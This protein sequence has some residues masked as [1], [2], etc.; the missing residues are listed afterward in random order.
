M[1]NKK[2]II[3]IVILILIILGLGSFIYYDKFYKTE[4]EKAILTTIDGTNF[5]LSTLYKIGDILN[6]FDVAFG[7]S[8]STYLGYIYKD[9]LYAKDFDEKAALYGTIY[10]DLA[11][12]N[13]NKILFG[14]NVKNNFENIF[15][16]NLTYNSS[17]ILDGEYIN[18]KYIAASDRYNYTI[19]GVY[20][21]YSPKYM[22]KTISTSITKDSIIVKRKV[23]YVE[24]NTSGTETISAN[25]YTDSGKS[26]NIGTIK[27]K[28]GI[29]NLN[30]IM[31]KYSSRLNT[32][33]Y[34]F[35]QSSDGD[36][37]FYS[38]EKDK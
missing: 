4:E 25:I 18:V 3:T 19:N 28:N 14:E 1:E 30:E 12:N 23:F 17:N 20:N 15:G 37:Y 38:I 21:T 33:K 2:F 27:L 29:I 5:D 16:D 6:R 36:Y 10:K 11:S 32:Y 34:I 35:K 7:D 26:K 13:G 31:A 24:Y 22:E 9:K 8:N